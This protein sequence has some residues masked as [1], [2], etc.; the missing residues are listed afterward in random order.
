MPQGGGGGGRSLVAC[1][2]R[3][4]GRRGGE[5][6]GTPR[7]FPRVR[8]SQGVGDSSG[9]ASSGQASSGQAFSGSR[10]PRVRYQVRHPRVRRSGVR[11]PQVRHSQGVDQGVRGTHGA[12][13]GAGVS[14][15]AR[16]FPRVRHPWDRHSWVRR[17]RVRRSRI[18]RSRVRHLWVRCPRVRRSWVRHP[19]VRHPQVIHPRVRCSRGVGLLGSEGL[20]ER[21]CLKVFLGQAFSGSRPPRVRGPRGTHG[22]WLRVG[23]SH[24]GRALWRRGLEARTTLSSGRVRRSKGV[25]DSSGQ[26]FPGSRSPR[27]RHS[28]VTHSP[29]RRSRVTHPRASGHEAAGAPE[30]RRTRA[31]G[32]RGEALGPEARRGSLVER[33]LMSGTTKHALHELEYYAFF[34]EI[35]LTYVCFSLVLLLLK[36]SKIKFRCLSIRRSLRST[37]RSRC[38]VDH[39]GWGDSPRAE[40][41]ARVRTLDGASVDRAKAAIH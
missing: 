40:L 36:E 27:V 7:R 13:L 38:D 39:I 17:P 31:S 30:E 4:S 10:P 16:R 5:P 32:G 2:A 33:C 25:G 8:Q 23:G 34:E 35:P 29:V 41:E 9:Q 26:A 19:W 24:T 11:H 1:K 22:V 3:A 20:E 37:N 6:R 14:R 12:C 21:V 28:L 18:R 15:H